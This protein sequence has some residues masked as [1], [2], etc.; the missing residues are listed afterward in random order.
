MKTIELRFLHRA[1]VHVAHK[2]GDPR[3]AVDGGAACHFVAPALD[4]FPEPA[5][6]PLHV[7]YCTTNTTAVR[8]GI[9]KRPLSLS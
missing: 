7:I 4:V 6:I 3:V 1:A 8:G 2:N 9:V 5:L